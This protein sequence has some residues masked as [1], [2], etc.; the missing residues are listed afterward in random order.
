MPAL[1]FLRRFGYLKNNIVV[2][3]DRAQVLQGEDF[4]CLRKTGL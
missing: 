3:D 4:V 1:P 2:G